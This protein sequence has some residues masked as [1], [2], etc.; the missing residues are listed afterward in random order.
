MADAG[1]T[2]AS[3]QLDEAVVNQFRSLITS[4]NIRTLRE[5]LTITSNA[6]N[7]PLNPRTATPNP[8]SEEFNK[9]FTYVTPAS[10]LNSG[11]T[12]TNMTLRSSSS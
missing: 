6:L 12:D 7:S 11:L 1:I 10:F 9:L 4:T 2:R 5:L 8:D 3:G